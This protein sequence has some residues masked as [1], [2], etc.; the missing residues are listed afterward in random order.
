MMKLLSG[1][2]IPTQSL[3]DVAFGQARRSLQQAYEMV[4][5]SSIF[6]ALSA[7]TKSLMAQSFENSKL[8]TVKDLGPRETADYERNWLLVVFKEE[9]ALKD[10]SEL[11]LKIVIALMQNYL[12]PPAQA[13]SFRLTKEHIVNRA[14]PES[15]REIMNSY[16]RVAVLQTNQVI[17]DL[18]FDGAT[19]SIPMSYKNRPYEVTAETVYNYL[20]QSEPQP[21]ANLYLAL[22]EKARVNP[23][24]AVLLVELAMQ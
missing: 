3:F 7:N 2:R 19:L 6:T 9:P 10:W 20:S 18:F 16:K 13:F 5:A 21:K 11:E 15:L 23:T 17:M 24:F 14:L 22:E 8:H 1:K 4:P 12:I